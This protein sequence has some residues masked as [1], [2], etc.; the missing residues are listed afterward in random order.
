MRVTIEIPDATRCLALNLAVDL[1]WNMA[2]AVK[3][4]ST[5]ELKDGAILY[6]HENL[7]KRFELKEDEE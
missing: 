7:G 4:F 5:E 2:M 3:V 6:A 1:G